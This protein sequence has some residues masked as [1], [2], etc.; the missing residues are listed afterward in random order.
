MRLW[1]ETEE[2][3]IGKTVEEL[4]KKKLLLSKNEISRAKF[5][6]Q[7]ILLDNVRV[8][9]T[10]KITRRGILEV[11]TENGEQLESKVLPCE[12]SLEILYEDSDVLAVN[13][14]S[15]MVCHP[16]HG[17]Y[18]D[19]LANLAAAHCGGAGKTPVI[20]PV[21]RLDRDTSGIVV[22]AK[23]R[24]AAARLAAQRAEGKFQKI[25]LAVAE[26]IFEEKQGTVRMPIGKCPDSLIK[27]RLDSNGKEAC[28]KYRVLREEG[29]IS[30]LACELETGRTHQ[31]RIHMAGMGHPLLG[32]CLYGQTDPTGRLALHAWKAE[33]RQPFTGEK[34]VITAE[35]DICSLK[36]NRGVFGM[37][38]IKVLVWNDG[39]QMPKKHP[40]ECYEEGAALYLWGERCILKIDTAEKES[41]RREGNTV[42]LTEKA[43]SAPTHRKALIKD[44]YQGC[45]EEALTKAA[46]SCEKITGLVAEEWTI[47]EMK[48]RWGICNASRRCIWLN[49]QLAKRP[50]EYL[51]YVML[52]EL[53]HFLEKSHNP[54]FYGY[55]D[56]FCP[57]WRAIRKRLNEE[58]YD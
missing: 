37:D 36:K 12:G 30:W 53:T 51:E 39:R 6:P 4:L 41:V 58:I 55:L 9:T 44:W 8:R 22:F 17:H 21:G 13:K 40:D 31:I 57:D 14:P 52:H 7:G 35:T 46:A 10:Q 25:Y 18:K 19:T 48:T 45:F 47:Q 23:N 26:G 2:E 54:V 24:V 33:F 16:S 1:C 34:I 5:L 38:G 42:V 28:T 56:G 50:K 43:G 49:L 15:G 32:D 20:R 27:M 29:N 11:R 3:D